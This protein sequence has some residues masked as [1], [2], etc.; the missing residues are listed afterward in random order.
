MTVAEALVAA[1]ARLAPV[2]ES[3]RFDAELLLGHVLQRSR[4]SLFALHDQPLASGASVSFDA[5]VAR[6]EAQE[7]VAYLTGSKG[8]W[9]LDLQVTPDV[10]VPRPETELL[11]EWSLELAGAAA[12]IADLGTGSGALALSLARER[13]Q[14]RIV[15]TDIS[16]SALNVARA[17][18]RS[19]GIANVGFRH[20]SWYAALE[21][22]F[23]LIVS[24]PPYIAANDPHMVA[25]RHEPALALTDGGDGMA[26][27]R[28]IVAGAGAHLQAGGWLLVEHGYDQGTDVRALFAAAGFEDVQTRR[29]LGG[30]ERATGGH[31]A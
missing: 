22:R 11:V 3:P 21:G 29:D 8:F 4:G 18:A 31:R 1:T 28:E 15:A 10:L 25:L 20:G 6:R 27:L 7:P 14:A 17:N 12:D 16:Q 23:D 5:L 2:S 13:P 24:N 26:C 30:Q 9:S 19:S